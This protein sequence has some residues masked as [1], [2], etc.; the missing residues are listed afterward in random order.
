VCACFFC[1]KLVDYFHSL[2]DSLLF[3]PFP[4]SSLQ[5]TVLSNHYLC[6]TSFHY[7]FSYFLRFYNMRWRSQNIPS[8]FLP[9]FLL[10]FIFH[11]FIHSFF[12]SCCTP[13]P[14]FLKAH[15]PQPFLQLFISPLVFS[16]YYASLSLSIPLSLYSSLSLSLSLSL[17]IPLSLYSSLSLFLSLSFSLSLYLPLFCDLRLETASIVT[18]FIASAL[19]LGM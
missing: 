19:A 14:C 15:F 12:I 10:S 7:H 6:P 2:S 1:Q 4:P 18:V 9:S 8:S 16:R 3:L 11:F 13:S 5:P 17:S